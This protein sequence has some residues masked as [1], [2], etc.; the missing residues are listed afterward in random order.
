MYSILLE[1]GMNNRIFDLDLQLLVDACI[2][3]AAVFTLFFFLSN[4]LFNPA[5]ELLKKRQQRIQEQLDNAASEQQSAL[6]FKAEYDTKLK[7]VNKEAEEILS[8]SRKKALKRET[9]IVN[10]AKDEAVKILDRASKEIDLEKAKVRD[11]MKKE[12]ITVAS[13]MAGKIVK[14]SLD[15]K[16][17]NQ[18][19]DETLREMGD[20]TWQS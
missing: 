13:A 17:Q 11:E 8:S 6:Q 15:E 2:M 16:T 4:M 19:I 12:M 18:L 9:E 10:E 20:G 7:E 1:A 5:R 3:A 14:S